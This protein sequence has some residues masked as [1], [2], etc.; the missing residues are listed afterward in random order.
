MELM[1]VKFVKKGADGINSASV[2]RGDTIVVTAGSKVHLN[3]RK[4]YTN[5]IEIKTQQSKTKR[6]SIPLKRS[7]R[8]SVAPFNSKTDCLFCGITIVPGSSDYSCVKTYA[9][10]NTILECCDSRFDNWSLAVKGRI[11]YYCGDLHAADCL[12][13]HSCSGNFRSGLDIPLQLRD[14]P[15]RKRKKTGRPKNQDQEQAFS[16]MCHFFESYDEEKLTISDL[17]GKMSEFLTDKDSLPYGNQ[18]LKR[19]CRND[20]E[21]LFI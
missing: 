15:E 8:A 21:N 16:K 4:R 18:F 14:G 13:H 3:C 20:M 1:Y 2:Q 7:C 17:S 12:Y 10:A 6:P 19:N 5:P 11:E 9:F